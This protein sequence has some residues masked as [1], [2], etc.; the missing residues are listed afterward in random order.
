VTACSIGRASPQSA[1]RK[2]TR[3]DAAGDDQ[4]DDID[5]ISCPTCDGSGEIAG[6]AT[7]PACGGEGVV[8][9]IRATRNDKRSITQIARDHKAHMDQIYQDH[10]RSLSE[11]WRK[12]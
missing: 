12:G 3:A 4:E 9:A 7:C 1:Y 2:P 5:E 11:A 10:A 6:G 8:P